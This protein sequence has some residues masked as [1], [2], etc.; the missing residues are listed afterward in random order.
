MRI[1][2]DIIL[3][4]IDRIVVV[5]NILQSEGVCCLKKTFV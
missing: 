3:E 4:T 5:V 1:V 2:H